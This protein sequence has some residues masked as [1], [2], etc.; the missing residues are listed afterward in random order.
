[1]YSFYLFRFVYRLAPWVFCWISHACRLVIS[2]FLNWN[3]NVFKYFKQRFA[4]VSECNCSVM[5]VSSLDQYMAI[6]SSH[7]RNCKNTNGTKGTSGH[8]KD[9]ALCNICTKLVICS[10]LKA[11]E[12]NISR[13]NIPFQSRPVSPLPAVFWP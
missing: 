9:L 1:M 5:R 4:P 7:F 8:R 13:N 10:T 2:D 3:P 11:E 12:G 6:E